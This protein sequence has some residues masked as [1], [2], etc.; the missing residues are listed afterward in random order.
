[1]RRLS[2]ALCVSLA[3]GL[4]AGPA[5]AQTASPQ[6]ESA[7]ALYDRAYGLYKL[8]KYRDAID[9]LNRAIDLD[10]NSPKIYV[11][12]GDA[13]ASSGDSHAAL[14]DYDRAIV[15]DPDTPTR[16]PRVAIR[17]ATSTITRARSPTAP[18]HRARRDGRRA[19]LNRGEVEDEMDDSSAA[20]G[21]FTKALALDKQYVYAFAD[22]CD[23]YRRKGDMTLRAGRLQ[24]RHRPQPQLRA[25]LPL[26]GGRL[27]RHEAM[28][29]G[30][31]RPQQSALARSRTDRRVLLPWAG[32]LLARQV[33]SRS[34]TRT[35][36]S[37][38]TRAIRTATELRG[39]I[40]AAR[41]ELTATLDFKQAI[42]LYRVAGQIDEAAATQKLL[43]KLTP[44]A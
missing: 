16:T 13:L 31:R 35:R 6:P 14:R 29:A 24:L 17:S 33:R 37:R 9:L 22:R 27:S 8:H 19:F 41:S 18:L 12:R 30:G 39:K 5:L 34:T 23:A 42:R 26:S 44:P 20:V 4:V 25:R 10:R 1:M 2:L 15:L 11:L 36:T 3:F 43:D 21:D 40:H 7:K 32:A 38:R 28:D